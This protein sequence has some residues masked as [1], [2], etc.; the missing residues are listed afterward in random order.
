MTAWAQ[1]EL[2][3][4]RAYEW[5]GLSL[6]DLRGDIRV[7][8]IFVDFGTAG[9]DNETKVSAANQKTWISRLN[10]T[11]SANHMGADGSVNDY[12]LAQSYGLLNVT[13]ESVGNYTASGSAASYADSNAWLARTAISSLTDVDWSRFDANGD[14]EVEC[15]LLIYAGHADGD[16]NAQQTPV[17]SIY[18]HQDWLRQS[19]GSRLKMGDA[20]VQSY[21]WMNNLRNGS[22]TAVN[23]TNTACHELSHGLLDLPD[24]YKNLVSYMGYMRQEFYDL[25]NGRLIAKNFLE[26]GTDV[27]LIYDKNATE[28][29]DCT[30]TTSPSY[31]QADDEYAGCTF[32]WCWDEQYGDDA[33]HNYG[34]TA[35]YPHGRDAKTYISSLCLYYGDEWSV[36][37]P[38]SGDGWIGISEIQFSTRDKVNYWEWLNFKFVD[39]ATDAETDYTEPD[40]TSLPVGTVLDCTASLNYDDF[41]L[42]SFTQT[43]VVVGKNYVA[44][45]DFLGSGKKVTIRYN[46]DGSTEVFSDYGYVENGVWYFRDKASGAWHEGFAGGHRISLSIE[47]NS[48]YNYIDY[49]QNGMMFHCPQ[50]VCDGTVGDYDDYLILKY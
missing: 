6:D 34:Y 26:S 40:P 1:H 13:F 27:T 5:S 29:V 50:I 45:D 35:F 43:G 11:N 16:D 48:Q 2:P 25:G 14:G 3:R 9:S 23:A 19:T 36:Y 8:V 24:Y 37:N 22:S 17:K 28:T 39:E 21:V 49:S 38:V 20:F 7:P 44:F 42:G 18:P 31:V 30:V 46:A 41:G 32:V 15:V 47:L 12:F 10:T 4:H 33:D